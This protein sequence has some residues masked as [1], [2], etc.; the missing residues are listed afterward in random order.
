MDILDLSM[1]KLSSVCQTAIHQQ[2][3][4]PIKCVIQGF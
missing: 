1:I 3:K 2:Q 4:N